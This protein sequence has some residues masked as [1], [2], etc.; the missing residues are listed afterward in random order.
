MYEHDKS[1][2]GLTV[3]LPYARHADMLL[4]AYLSADDIQILKDFLEFIA[5]VMC[6]ERSGEAMDHTV[7]SKRGEATADAVRTDFVARDSV[8]TVVLDRPT[9]C[10]L[11]S[12][13]EALITCVPEEQARMDN[14]SWNATKSKLVELAN[15]VEAWIA[16]DRRTKTSE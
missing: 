4:P 1:N 12:K 7:G 2:I 13:I 15:I 6:G 14:G 16:V 8:G 9:I 11:A 10:H 3:P 5:P